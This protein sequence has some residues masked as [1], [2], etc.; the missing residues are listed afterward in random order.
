LH[1]AVISSP[2]EDRIREN[3]RGQELVNN[4]GFRKLPVK[5]SVSS[6]GGFRVLVYNANRASRPCR[7]PDERW[8]SS[9]IFASKK[10]HRHRPPALGFSLKSLNSHLFTGATFFSGWIWRESGLFFFQAGRHTQL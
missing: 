5:R 4:Y 9:A 8:V 10:R 6:A 7:D 2:S 1:Q 3:R